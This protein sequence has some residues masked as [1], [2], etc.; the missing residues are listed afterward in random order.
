MQLHICPRPLDLRPLY[1]SF[2]RFGLCPR[3][4]LMSTGA[5]WAVRRVLSRLAA[6]DDAQV[7]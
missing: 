7:T 2:Y 5:C 6:L 4:S 1:K 3:E